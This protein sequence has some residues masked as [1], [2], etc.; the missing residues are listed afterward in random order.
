MK[1][2]KVEL[3][4]KGF[5][6]IIKGETTSSRPVMLNETVRMAHAL[7]ERKIQAKNERIDE[8]L[9][10]KWENN[11]QGNNNNNYSHN[12][13][14]YRNNNHHN[15]NNNRR[16]NNARALTR[17]QNVRANKTGISPKWKEDTRAVYVRRT[18]IDEVET[19]SSAYSKIDLRFGYHQLQIREEDIPITAFWTKYGHFEFQVMPFDLT[20][21]L[22]VFMDFMNQVCKPYL[23]KFV[24]VI[25]DDILIYS[26]NKEDHEKH[27]KTILELLKNEN[28]GVNVDPAKVEAI[29]NWSAPTT[30]MEVRQFLGLAGYYRRFI[31]GFLLISKPLSKLTQKNKKYE[32]GMEE[33]EEEAFQ[34]LKHKLCSAPILALPEGNENFI[35]YCD[36]LLKGF[37]AVLMQREKVIAYASRQLKKHEENYTTHDFKL[38]AKELNT[39]QRC[40]IELLTDYDCE[41]HYH[42]GKGNVVADALSQKERE[43][44]RVR[45]LWELIL[46]VGTLSWQ[47]ECLVHFIPNSRPV[48]PAVPKPHVTRPRPAKTIVTKLHSPPKRNI[49]H[50]PSPKA[51]TSPSKVNAAKAPM[52]NAVKGAKAV[53][54]ACYVQNR[55]LVTQPQNKTPYEFLL[56][57]TPSIGCMRPFGCPVTILNTLDPL[58][59]EPKF[60][61]R[62]PESEAHVSPSSS[63]Q[64][65]KHDD[66]TKR[67]A[68]GK[69]LTELPTRYRNL[70]AEFEDFADNSI[71]EVNA[72]DSLVPAVGGIVVR[73]KARLVAQ[74]HTQEEGIDYEEV[75]APVARIEDIRP[76]TPAV[77]KPHVTRPRPAKTV[78]TKLHSPPKRNINHSPSLKAS[79]F[80]SKVNAA[81]APM[82]NPV[83]GDKGVIDSGCSRHMTGNMSYLSDFEEINCGYVAF[84]G[85]PKGG[86]ISGKDTECTVLSHEFKLLDENQVLLRIPQENNMYNVDLKNIVPSVDLTCLFA[87]ATLDESNLW[88]RRLGHINFK[89]MNKLVKGKSLTE[90]P[91]RYR[92]LS[93]EFEDFAD[94]SI[95][96]VNADDSL[97][98]A[99]GQISANSTNTFS[100]AGPSN[101]VVLVDLPNGK[102]AIGTKWVFRNKKDERGIVV[103]NKARLVAQGHTQEEGIDYEEVFA[104][105]ARIEDIRLFLSYASFMGFMD[106][107]YPDKV[108]K[109]VKA[110][111]GLHQA[112]RAWYETLAKYLL[113]NDLCKAFEKLIKDKFQMS[114]MGELTFFLGLQ[115]KKKQDGIFI[116]HDKYVAKILRKFGLTARKSASSPID[117]KKPLLKDPDGEDVDV[118]TYRSMIGSLMYLTLSRPDIMF[119]VYACARFQVTP[120]A[121]HLHAIKRIFRYFK[122]KPHLGLWYPKDSPFNLVAYSDSD[123]AGASLDRKSTT[124]GCQFLGSRLIS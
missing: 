105:V 112:P 57:R 29:R 54:T 120:K 63:A 84:G 7:M 56:G 43:P 103:R 60:K 12:Q 51:S 28:N 99:V 50:S 66:K 118:H 85:Y 72:A 10:R 69:S 65:K 97:V 124:E 59:K 34:T 2:K 6:E 67:E 61:G 37:G 119:V 35:V 107:D 79:T 98:P 5:L 23:D 123:Y 46:L 24:I 8:G 11:N 13:G 90:L 55:V 108:Y 100:A 110:L 1:R 31:E 48:T 25:I 122:G 116:S 81:K 121:S 42:P 4:I 114:S 45:S 64:T 76:V 75:F 101:T 17:D 26:K 39:R 15:Q 16:Q 109:V 14:N 58:V 30:P 36:A 27:L 111:Y 113:E 3:Y 117:T 70:S 88:H 106:P 21:A 49:N 91:T 44:L 104:P 80:P 38:G 52:V 94:N 83:K 9:K 40:W 18:L 62:K 78:V 22:A 53:Y 41:I 95:N 86:K 47:R 82:V 20:N 102:R 92:N 71:N 93:A 74:G 89:T 73:N 115:V 32:S 96:E 33:E 68:K 87:K 77:P 19:C